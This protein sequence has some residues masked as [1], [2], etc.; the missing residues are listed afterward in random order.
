MGRTRRRE[1]NKDLNNETKE[2]EEEDNKGVENFTE[3]KSQ[4][5][6]DEVQYGDKYLDILVNESYILERF[7]TFGILEGSMIHLDD[8]QE[9]IKKVFSNSNNNNNNNKL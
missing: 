2:E 3:E 7:Y 5:E 6:D 9:Y 1:D 8:A 4:Q